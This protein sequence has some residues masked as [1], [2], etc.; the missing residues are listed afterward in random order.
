MTSREALRT[1]RRKLARR[2]KLVVFFY[3]C[4][5]AFATLAVLP[6]ALLIRDVLGHSV[7]SDRQFASFSADWAME[8]LRNN[9]F[10]PMSMTTSL[11]L[12]VGVLFLLWSTFL[13]GGAIALFV[14]ERDAFFSAC[15]RFFPRLFRLF[16]MSLV[17]YAIVLAING[18][19]T[20]AQRVAFRDSMVEHTVDVAS[21]LR[22]AVT[23]FLL[24]L[25][26]MAFDYAKIIAI[27]DDRPKAIRCAFRGMG[28]V[29]T[30]FRR[31]LGIYWLCMLIGFV[32]L[33]V[34]HYG[35]QAI[36]QHTALT[37][38]L[39]LAIR[40]V[41]VIARIWVRLLAFSSETQYYIGESRPLAEVERAIAA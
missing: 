23:F 14:H 41:Y 34:C 21:W 13:D 10:A 2:R 38:L 4:N 28:F 15:A 36:T 1:G 17:F 37:V 39:V 35:A 18:G 27:A 40:Q 26:N 24:T 25:V 8:F 22:V 32:F 33:V 16:L 20:S 12:G 9:N 3:A 7:E 5:L 11:L 30:N 31:T 19:L 6:I 29:R